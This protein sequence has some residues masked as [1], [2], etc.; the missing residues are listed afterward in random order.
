MTGRILFFWW[1]TGLCLLISSPSL[2]A[3]SL[4]ATKAQVIEELGKPLSQASG[5]GREILS[6]P[7][8]VRLVLVDGRVESAKGILLTGEE[9]ETAEV[10]TEPKKSPAASVAKEPHVT[11]EPAETP[12]T[13]EPEPPA[14]PP[15][16]AHNNPNS[17]NSTLAPAGKVP[18][19]KPAHSFDP[20]AYAEREHETK[21]NPVQSWL[22]LALVL[23]FHFVATAIALKL[24]FKFW[25]MDSLFSGLLA[26]AGIDLAVH[27]GLEVL[28]PFVYNLSTMPVVENGIAGFVL[29]FTI[30]HFCFN[31]NIADAIQTASVVK[32]AVTLLKLFGLMAVL[33]SSIF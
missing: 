13:A 5:G 2:S 17:K 3:V 33:N 11:E 10:K 23:G 6:Y 16:P 8:G 25:N 21:S 32:I 20:S 31:K 26:I 22:R 4:G 15:S 9:A 12:E 30:R 19:A 24:A 18:N 29:I 27:V 14:P 1:T 28:G 7:K